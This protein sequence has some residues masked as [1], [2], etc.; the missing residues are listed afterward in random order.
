MPRRLNGACVLLTRETT[1]V[2]ACDERTE[3]DTMPS[4]E[5]GKGWCFIEDV[6]LF[7]I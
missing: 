3:G 6:F 1:T 2:A 5:G 4:P 7:G